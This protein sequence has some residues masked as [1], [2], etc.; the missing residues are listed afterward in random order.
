MSNPLQVLHVTDV[1]AMGYVAE[2]YKY[3]SASGLV[4]ENK[5]LVPGDK[6]HVHQ[7]HLSFVS[8]L[9][10]PVSEIRISYDL[11]PLSVTNSRRRPSFLHFIT[12]VKV[13]LQ[14]KLRSLP[15]PSKLTP[16][17]ALRHHRWCVH[18]HGPSRRVCVRLP[19]PSHLSALWHNFQP[20]FTCI[21][22]ACTLAR[23]VV[24]PRSPSCA[25]TT[26][27]AG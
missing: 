17:A 12:Q 5:E 24:V 6:A 13:E 19:R 21:M 14:R 10:T 18:C 1:S 23:D 2:E 7:P 3:T 15:A 16:P 26:A 9:L 8:L 27:C 25:A 22:R 20:H 11:S 4:S